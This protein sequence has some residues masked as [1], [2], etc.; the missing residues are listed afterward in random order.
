MEKKL[1]RHCQTWTNTAFVAVIVLGSLSHARGQTEAI[2]KAQFDS[3]N[4]AYA[5]GEFDLAQTGYQTVLNDRVHFEAEFNL[6]NAFFKQQKYGLAILH[7]ER[8]RQLTPGHED[9]GTNLILAN[10]QISDRIEA[11][12]TAGI[13]ELWQGV[14]APG[15][16]IIWQRL[17]IAFWTFGF[18][19]LAARIFANNL[20]NRRIWGTVG[21]SFLVMGIA[22]SCLSWAAL[23]R[24]TNDQ[25][26]IVLVG[27]SPVR[28]QP[29]LTGLT[30]FMVHEGTKISIVQ[31]EEQFTKIELPNGNVG[32]I[33]S[34]D[35]E[36]I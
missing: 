27:E 9:L 35:M 11:L 29:G 21:T 3:A 22:F 28:S 17:M 20:G 25:S 2:Y 5:R 36:A 18:I 26:A 10:S 23:N 4:E 14:V 24:I 19:A 13:S 30:L 34:K 32:W 6:G 31:K 12:P 1:K 33:E 15:R 8:A 7:Y 16:Y